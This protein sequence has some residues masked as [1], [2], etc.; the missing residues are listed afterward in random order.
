MH[1]F[2][3]HYFKISYYKFGYSA[4]AL[5]MTVQVTSAHLYHC[6]GTTVDKGRD[7]DIQVLRLNIT[8]KRYCE[9]VYKMFLS[10]E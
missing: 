8:V 2:V 6:F 9:T 7:S 5:Y 3:A 4:T 10:S 1:V